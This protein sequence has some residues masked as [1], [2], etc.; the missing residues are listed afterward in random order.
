MFESRFQDFDE[1]A[2]GLRGAE[3]L[4]LLRAE[5]S[6]RGVDGFLV[7][8]ADAHQ[9]EYVPASEERL[10]WLTGFTGSAGSAAVL[11]DRAAL[12]VD[13]RYTVQA[14]EQV[15]TS[16]FTPVNVL[17][18]TPTAW[19]REHAAGLRIG[20]DPWLHT[21]D[22]VDRL[23]AAGV[24]LVPLALNPVDVIW[25]D[26]PRPPAE[27]ITAHEPRLAGEDAVSK[28]ARVQQEIVSAG[29]DHLL[30]TDPHAIAWLFNIRG[31]DVAHTPLPLAWALISAD[32]KPL[33]LVQSRKLTNLLR[34]E[35]AEI[36]EIGEPERLEQELAALGQAGRTVMLD[37][38]MTADHLRDVLE[39]NGARLKRAADPI[40][41]LKAVKNAAEIAG[42]REAHL[43]DGAA[44]ARFLCWFDREAAGGAI[45]EITAA[46]AL[47][48]FRRETGQL[49]DVSFPT[50]SAAGPN[51]AL[52]HYRVTRA[53]NRR[54][55]PGLFLIDSGAQYRDGTTDI[56]RT[57]AVGETTP[58]M[59]DRYTRVLKGHIAIAT[60]RFP[61]GS[62]GAQLDP[63]ARRALWDVGADFDHGTGHGVGS[64][65]SVH[66][67][68][69]RISKLG[70]VAL[71]AGM[72]L[73]NEPGY[74][75]EG[76]IGI[77]IE[78]LVLVKED[79]RPGD[80]RPMLAFETLTFAPIDT[81]PLALD[82]LTAEERAWL[83]AYHE[84]VAAKIRPLLDEATLS[85]ME[86]A[87]ASVR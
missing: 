30:L 62:S 63:F 5:L 72:I 50:I 43:R 67:G 76:A 78:N 75:R 18:Q 80:E 66:E 86:R 15:D 54:I 77:R 49:M 33:L 28:I 84:Q 41:K 46:Q 21:V 8:R 87:C 79:A 42:T 19:L 4:A 24:T 83:N 52:P 61:K 1:R 36:A 40:Q 22:A 6:A 35:L 13:G 74:Y 25:T 9:N 73:S 81:R 60:A 58:E 71:E 57:I 26:R 69:Q 56:T 59:R 7:P 85:W 20:F 10:A 14:R 32:N 27:P 70:H 39:T 37:T 65:L 64:Y 11:M 45:D 12:F 53:T 31:G 3:R 29:A 55:D 82:L 44:M 47:E 38:S 23:R 16:A 34:D 68:P 51:A 17:D 2:D 48:T